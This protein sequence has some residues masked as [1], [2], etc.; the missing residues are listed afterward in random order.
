VLKK[1]SFNSIKEV[2][3]A[4]EKKSSKKR[5]MVTVT[6]APISLF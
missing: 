3:F 4:K 6:V 2:N 5:A 1:E